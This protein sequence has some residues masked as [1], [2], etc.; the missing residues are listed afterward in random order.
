MDGLRQTE[1]PWRY[2]V[3]EGNI[4]AGKTTLATMLSQHF[5][6]KLVLEQFSDNPFLPGFYKDRKKY[7][8]P[9]ELSF[10]AER[11]QQL[12]DELGKP[13]L[14][15]QG[16]VADYFV[17]KSLIF[18]QITLDQPEFELFGRLFKIIRDSLPLP[19]KLIYLHSDR[20]RLLQNIRHRGRPYEQEIQEDYL[21]NIQSGYFE[22]LRSLKNLPVALVDVSKIDFVAHNAD[23]ERMLRLVHLPLSPGMHYFDSDRLMEV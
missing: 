4:G 1:N 9:L 3:I 8:F 7:A 14:F 21:Q 20:E 18:A 15:Q 19:D 22:L 2:L 6:S 11:Y 12:K 17:L 13:D 5:S 23:F 16:I 10:L